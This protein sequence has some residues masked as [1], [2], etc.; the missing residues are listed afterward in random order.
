MFIVQ[1]L[2]S[3]FFFFCYNLTSWIWKKPTLVWVAVAPQLIWLWIL[4]PSYWADKY[5]HTHAHTDTKW[6]ITHLCLLSL[7]FSLNMSQ[8][9]SRPC[10]VISLRTNHVAPFFLHCSLISKTSPQRNKLPHYTQ[11]RWHGCH[12]IKHKRR[13]NFSVS[14]QTGVSRDRCAQI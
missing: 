14:Q 5:T 7:S 9:S 11:L 3:F 8:L 10:Y 4:F 13:R 1:S 2:Y 12:L 6:T